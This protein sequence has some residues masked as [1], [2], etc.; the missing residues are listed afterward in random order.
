MAELVKESNQAKEKT[1]DIALI[2]MRCSTDE[3][4]QM[5]DT[6][7]QKCIHLAKVY[8]DSIEIE[9]EYHS[10]WNKPRP[11]FKERLKNI[12]KYKYWISYDLDRFSR[13]DPH[14]ANEYLNY[15][16]H[17][18]NVRFLTI[19][20][21]IDS[22]D[23]I[24]WN[25]V[26]HIMVWQ[27]NKYSEKLSKRIK[28]GINYYKN[29]EKEETE[30]EL[31]KKIKKLWH[32][33]KKTVSQIANDLGLHTK[34]VHATLGYQH[35]RRRKAD[36]KAILALYKKRYNISQI[37]KKLGYSKGCVFYAINQYGGKHEK[38]D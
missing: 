2:Y 38:R 36:Y 34:I 27:A 16:V 31:S 7:L 6:Q 11:K 35:G 14:I 5:V 12:K 8:T 23:E 19:N 25:I 1:K 32:E 37:A 17:K 22:N 10:A 28:E 33:D 30:T 21:S 26:R 20:D 29:I 24:K 18:N 15:I 13:D 3:D 4:R 9:R